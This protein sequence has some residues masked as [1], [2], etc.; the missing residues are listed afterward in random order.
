MHIFST[1]THILLHVHNSIIIN[2]IHDFFTNHGTNFQL[3][4]ILEIAQLKSMGN[5]THKVLAAA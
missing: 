5:G 4:N 2:H 1:N 3:K